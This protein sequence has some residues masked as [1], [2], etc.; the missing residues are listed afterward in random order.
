M[1][2]HLKTALAR[3]LEERILKLVTDLQNKSLRAIK[4]GRELDDTIQQVDT[5]LIEANEALHR[6]GTYQRR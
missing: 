5:K 3:E 4:S 6:L 1:T 2:S